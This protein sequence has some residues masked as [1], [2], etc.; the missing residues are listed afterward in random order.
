[1]QA[2]ASNEPGGALAVDSR[3][4]SH[5]CLSHVLLTPADGSQLLQTRKEE[6]EERRDEGEISSSSLGISGTI[7]WGSCITDSQQG[8]S[9][10]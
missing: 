6:R 2:S 5:Y 8:F 4:L 7:T 3:T 9:H 1:M 10:D